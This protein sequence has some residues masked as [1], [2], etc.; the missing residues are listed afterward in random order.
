MN[1]TAIA[2]AVALILGLAAAPLRAQEAQPQ[3]AGGYGEAEYRDSCAACHGLDGRGGGALAGEL[4]T[5]PSDL[6]LLAEGNGG[7]FPYWRVF[8]VIDGRYVVA[9]HGDRDMPVWGRHFLDEETPVFGPRGGELAAT[10]RIHALAGYIA[11]LQ[12]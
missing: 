3:E 1:V 8:A 10:E 6:T 12:R 5:S 11:S 7:E 9:G 2:G 4:R